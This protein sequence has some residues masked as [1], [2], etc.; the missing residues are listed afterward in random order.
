MLCVLTLCTG[1][2]LVMAAVSDSGSGLDYKKKSWWQFGKSKPQAQK[3]D[4]L[5]K[6]LKKYVGTLK[7]FDKEI[8]EDLKVADSINTYL[9]TKNAKL[10]EEEKELFK[11]GVREGKVE[12][13][14]DAKKS[15]IKVQ[16][17]VQ[18]QR[19]TY[20]GYLKD[21]QNKDLEKARL[22][23]IKKTTSGR[24]KWLKTQRKKYFEF[25]GLLYGFFGGLKSLFPAK[26]QQVRQKRLDKIVNTDYFKD[27]D[28]DTKRI[29]EKART[30]KSSS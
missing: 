25:Q 24:E 29:L 8:T 10:P 21:L 7:A 28:E 14:G 13:F 22:A 11:S 23:D 9:K 30:P 3:Q 4:E 18:K 20:K 1:S 2:S 12:S 6:K 17:A 5:F 26:Q 16:E 27:L 19:D 15:A